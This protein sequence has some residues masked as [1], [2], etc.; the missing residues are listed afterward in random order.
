MSTPIYKIL[1]DLR[2]I[3]DSSEELYSLGTRDREN[4]KVFRD[5]DSGVIYIKDFYVGD[6]EYE[7]G[8]YR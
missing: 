5:S 7:R 1:S 8:E 3:K 4:I 6:E 2:L